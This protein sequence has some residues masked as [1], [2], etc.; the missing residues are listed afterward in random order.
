MMNMSM[1]AGI[2]G[3]LWIARAGAAGPGDGTTWELDAIAGVFI[4]GA[5]VAG[6]IGTVFG[7]VIGGLVMAVLNN[8]LQLVGVSTDRMQVVKGAV[9]LIAVGIDV[10]NKQQGRPSLIG[11]MMARLRANRAR[12]ELTEINPEAERPEEPLDQSSK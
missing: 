9:L 2:A 1:L 3:M 8:G 6:G 11:T 12:H 5:A 4:G 7:S 10:L